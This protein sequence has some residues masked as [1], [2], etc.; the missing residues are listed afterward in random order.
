LL[1]QPIASI[2]GAKVNAF[3][4]S[5]TISYKT[6]ATHTSKTSIHFG[7]IKN[8]FGRRRSTNLVNYRVHIVCDWHAKHVIGQDAEMGFDSLANPGHVLN[9]E[10]QQFIF[11]AYWVGKDK[12]NF[13]LIFLL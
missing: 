11:M 12:L 4:F 13:Q 7:K 9:I 10:F 8:T 6:D 5:D 3:N 1:A 2:D